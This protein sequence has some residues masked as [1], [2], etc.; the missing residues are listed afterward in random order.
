MSLW[1]FTYA[2]HCAA[3]DLFQYSPWFTDLDG[4]TVAQAATA[5]DAWQVQLLTHAGG[6]QG[7]FPN[8]TVWA[9]PVV[10]SIDQA[11]GH[12]ISAGAGISTGVGTGD[13]STNHPLPPQC[14]VCVTLR[15][16]TN[17]GHGRGR[18]Y[19]P[20]PIITALDLTGRLTSAFQSQLVISL[21]AAY[22]AA[23]TATGRFNPVVYSRS[24]RGT[25]DVVTGDIGNLVDTQ[26]RRRNKIAESRT[27][28][29]P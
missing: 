25:L 19:L 4:A 14:A 29:A 15:S 17:T 20:A 21:N 8:N 11:S 26:R 24:L 12:E 13:A 10:A 2:G 23:A 28:F 16:A 9:N 3:G 6:V 5:A 1:R 18:F 22:S 27:T 7:F